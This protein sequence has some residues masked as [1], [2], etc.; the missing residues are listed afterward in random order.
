M[1]IYT[2]NDQS[3]RVGDW[4]VWPDFGLRAMFTDVCMWGNINHTYDSPLLDNKD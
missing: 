2:Q 4:D 3:A 1:I